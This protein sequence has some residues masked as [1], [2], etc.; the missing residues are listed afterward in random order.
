MILD[1]IG[2]L[3]RLWTILGS[4]RLVL[5]AC[6]M[7]LL[8]FACYCLRLLAI[9]CFGLLLLAF[10]LLS[11]AFASCCLLLLAATQLE[12]KFKMSSTL[13]RANACPSKQK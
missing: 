8:A 11:L 1:Y 4:F 10:G 2:L 6:C 7:L 12:F 13:C 9:G 3:E 5:P